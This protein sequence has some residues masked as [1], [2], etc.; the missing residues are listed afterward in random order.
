MTELGDKTELSSFLQCGVTP[1]AV[2]ACVEKNAT[3][4]P[5]NP[6][7]CFAALN[8]PFILAVDQWPEERSSGQ[9]RCVRSHG[10]FTSSLQRW[11]RSCGKRSRTPTMHASDGHL[12]F[13]KQ[14]GQ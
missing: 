10:V 12:S 6:P 9:E 2:A 14:N 5:A 1:R 3:P 11:M 8:L 7:M 4:A 13:Q